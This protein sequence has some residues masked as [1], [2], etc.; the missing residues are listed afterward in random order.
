MTTEW[1]CPLQLY[2]F[3]LEVAWM[4][5]QSTQ[6]V[7]ILSW[8]LMPAWEAQIIRP[9]LRPQVPRQT[10]VPPEILCST[11]F[12]NNASHP[13]DLWCNIVFSDPTWPL[14]S[15]GICQLKMYVGDDIPRLPISCLWYACVTLYLLRRSL[16]HSDH[17]VQTGITSL[18]TSYPKKLSS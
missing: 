4:M 8:E 10:L 3:T 15:H 18:T 1:S 2:S 17:H 16:C 7:I 9:S 6:E 5:K 13:C 14:L 12:D 11:P